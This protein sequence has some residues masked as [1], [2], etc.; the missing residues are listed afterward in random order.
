MDKKLNNQLFNVTMR[1][2]DGDQVRELVGAQ[3][4]SELSNI[5]KNTH[6]GLYKDDGQIIIR[7]TNGPKLDS[8]RK[9]I[10]NALKLQGF[11]ISINTNLKIVNFLD[12]TLNFKKS[13]FEPYK[14]RERYTYLHTH[15]FKPLTLVHQTNIKIK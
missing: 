10:S 5:I 13:S 3:I 15:F 7:N 6:M 8:Y 9:R 4:L 14:K 2:F 11:K 1:S 12:V